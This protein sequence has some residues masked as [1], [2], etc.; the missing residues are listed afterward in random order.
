MTQPQVTSPEKALV[1]A[2]RKLYAVID[3]LDQAAANKVGVS[4]NDL[5]ALNELEHGP[6]RAGHFSE[7][8]GLT[9]GAVSSLI[10]RLE[11]LGLAER[12]PDPSDRRAILV[13]P[14]EKLFLELAPLYRGVADRLSSLAKQYNRD[15]VEAS[16]KYLQDIIAA[17]EG[18]L[19]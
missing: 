4:R 12:I 6:V 5:R 2:C 16:L 14:K 15:E 18:A 19:E 10:D 7:T 17:Y 8:L 9:T 11:R 13:A 1:G 3:R